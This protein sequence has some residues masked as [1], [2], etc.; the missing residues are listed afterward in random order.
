M[1]SATPSDSPCCVLPEQSVSV[2]DVW[3]E[4]GRD[5]R[6]FSYCDSLGLGVG[7]GD[8]VSVRLR[9]RRLQGLVTGCRCLEKESYAQGLLVIHCSLW[10]HWC[11]PLRSMPVG[12]RGSTPW[13]IDATPVLSGCSKRPC[14]P[15]GW[16]NGLLLRRLVVD[17]G[18]L[19][20][21]MWRHPSTLSSASRQQALMDALAQRGGGAWQRDL[22]AEGFQSG[23]IQA[24]E[25]KG[26][27]QREQRSCND[28]ASSVS[29]PFDA[30]LPREL[31]EE[32]QAALT[33]FQRLPDG[34]EMLLWGITGSGKTEV[35]LQ[36][37]AAEL[38]AGRH[39]LMLTPE[40]GLIPQLVDRCRKRFG[41][42]VVEY[43]SGCSDRERVTT[44][45]RCLASDEPI[46]VVGAFGR[47]SAAAPAGI[48]GA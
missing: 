40:I 38:K 11:N 28:L 12:G 10:M 45:R 6:T 16:G 39:V 4:A 31:T 41:A 47:V 30:E 42:Q 14:H 2:V 18:G 1:T 3:L 32:Q 33:R 23:S 19:P 8:L 43:H 21:G 24:L 15:D 5:G 27:I 37:A 13:R 25:S 44:W 7:L 36:L 48:A 35:Y 17:C 26:L 46:V 29:P 22:L 9:G 20:C 34:S